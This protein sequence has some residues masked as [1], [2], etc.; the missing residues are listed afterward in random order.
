[1][2]IT[3]AQRRELMRQLESDLGPKVA[4]VK[5]EGDSVP[6]AERWGHLLYKFLAD[7]KWK[8]ADD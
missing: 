4:G 1:L 3:K 6:A 5:L 8:S 2:R 7:S